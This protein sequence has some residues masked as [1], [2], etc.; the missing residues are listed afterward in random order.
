M[1]TNPPRRRRW[2]LWVLVGVL[3]VVALGYGAIFF[4]TEVLNDPEDELTVDDLEAALGTAAPTTTAAPA[5]A[6]SSTVPTTTEAPGPSPVEGVWSVTSDSQVGYRVGENLFGV[7]TEGVGR[8]NQVTGSITIEGTQVAEGDFTVD[9]TTLESDDSR[10]DNQ[11]R[12]RIMATDEF[13][14]ATFALTAPIELGRIPD[15]GEQITATATGDL[16]LRGITNPVTF[17]VTAQLTGERIGVLGSIP[18]VFADYDI[19]NPSIAG[20]TTDDNGLLEFVL[21]FER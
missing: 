9:M 10:R 13:P 17:D 16:T 8:T 15:E 18:I 3:A 11:F 2:W 1:E 14:T 12:G 19:P 7:D 20:I 21:V 6:G 4:Y 5:P